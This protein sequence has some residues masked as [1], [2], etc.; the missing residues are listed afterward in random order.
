MP[1]PVFIDVPRT[2]TPPVIIEN[3][4]VDIPLTIGST[5]LPPDVDEGYL[6]HLSEQLK[7][8]FPFKEYTGRTLKPTDGFT[9]S[10]LMHVD[11]RPLDPVDDNYFRSHLA[12]LFFTTAAANHPVY[13]PNNDA[14]SQHLTYEEWISYLTYA[15]GMLPNDFLYT[16]N[17]VRRFF[18]AVGLVVTEGWTHEQ[19]NDG[20]FEPPGWKLK[21]SRT[22][23]LALA[24]A[25][26]MPWLVAGIVAITGVPVALAAVGLE[27]AA[28]A[29]K[30]VLTEVKDGATQ[31]LK[32]IGSDLKEDFF[33]WDVFKE[34]S[35]Q[36]VKDNVQDALNG[37]RSDV[38]QYIKALTQ[39]SGINL[40]AVN[41]AWRGFSSDTVRSI[42][43]IMGDITGKA[44]QTLIEHTTETEKAV[45]AGEGQVWDNMLALNQA[46]GQAF[47][48]GLFNM[49]FVKAG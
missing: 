39:Q 9:A 8:I 23:K 18:L 11:Y 20:Y 49:L 6:K 1:A 46:T 41:E 24:V 30:E 5:T 25:K 47:A 17:Y 16:N 45:A 2:A 13:D 48:D 33:S 19:L 35:V 34:I 4:F 31:G 10:A 22:E 12:Q 15:D 27:G 7:Q 28:E 21:V 14:N 44:L 36:I 32:D 42:T 26:V 38:D 29:V 43:N 3:K 40:S 37:V